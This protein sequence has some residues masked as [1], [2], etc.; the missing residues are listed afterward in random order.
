MS[1]LYPVN[2]DV[3]PTDLIRLVSLFKRSYKKTVKEINT[4]TD[5][6]VAN[7]KAILAQI[8]DILEDLGEDVQSFVDA[9]LPAYYKRGAVD[10]VKQLKN[11]GVAV[12]IETGFS[13]L[14]RDAIVALVDDTVRAYAESI[15][16]VKRSAIRLLGSA[17]RTQVQDEIA[18][19]ALTGEALRKVRRTIKGILQEEGLSALVDKSGRKWSPD[20]YADM[21]FRTKV[22]EARNMGLANRMVENGYDLVQ[23]SAHIGT[24][25]IC[26]PWEGKIL[27]ITGDSRGYPRLQTATEAGLFHPNCRHAINTLVPSVAR[28][29][30]AYDPVKGKLIKK[31]GESLKRR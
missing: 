27:S 16:G 4:S 19:G 30:K 28:K 11:A 6:G 14:H 25:P 5:F 15:T 7:R 2:V 10:A 17:V 18:H 24:C 1:K 23:V 26:A 22:V 9:E 8:D 31:R 13:Q 29:T 21:L 3:N 20:R 12:D